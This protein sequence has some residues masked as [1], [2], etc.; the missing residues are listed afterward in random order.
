[1][2]VC[3]S[4]HRFGNFFYDN[5]TFSGCGFHSP[6]K[7]RSWSAAAPSLNFVAKVKSATSNWEEIFLGKIWIHFFSSDVSSIT[8]ANNHHHQ[9]L[10]ELR[11]CLVYLDDL[12]LSPFYLNKFW[13]MMLRKASSSPYSGRSSAVSA[14]AATKSTNSSSTKEDLLRACSV[15]SPSSTPSLNALQKLR[16]AY[17]H[18]GGIVCVRRWS[19]EQHPAVI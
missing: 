14:L 18:P 3:G 1:M 12:V 5:G 17:D 13:V 2:N 19:S 8:C 10:R 15:L 16:V 9:V 11:A 7:S 6:K 4:H